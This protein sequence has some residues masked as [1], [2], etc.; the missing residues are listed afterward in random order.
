MICKES[1]KRERHHIHNMHS[2][3]LHQLLKILASSFSL[4]FFISV[5]DLSLSLCSYSLHP[6][7]FISFMVHPSSSSKALQ[8]VIRTQIYISP[9]SSSIFILSLS[10]SFSSIFILSLSSYPFSFIPFLLISCCGFGCKLYI[11]THYSFFLF[12]PLPQ[13]Q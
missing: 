12:L 4:Y 2:L 6:S 8:C 7:P 1:M 3:S 9:S 5:S 10:L 13:K 11:Q